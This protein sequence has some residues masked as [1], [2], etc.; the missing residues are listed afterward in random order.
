MRYII[1]IRETNPSTT[2]NM[3]LK[4]NEIKFPQADLNLKDKNIILNKFRME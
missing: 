3:V 4:D 2:I 1:Q